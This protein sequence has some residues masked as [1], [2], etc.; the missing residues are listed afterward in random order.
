MNIGKTTILIE[1]KGCHDCGTR[2]AVSWHTFKTIHLNVGK[3]ILQ[4][5]IPICGSCY[6]K[7]KRSGRDLRAVEFCQ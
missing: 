3:S 4:L 5:D 2:Y 6:K 1:A 7:R